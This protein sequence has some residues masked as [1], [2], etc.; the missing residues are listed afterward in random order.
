[1]TVRDLTPVPVVVMTLD[2]VVA[3]FV[4]TGAKLAQRQLWR[5][6]ECAVACVVVVD[7]WDRH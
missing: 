2:L 7:T 3:C 1:M 6:T 5:E 4:P